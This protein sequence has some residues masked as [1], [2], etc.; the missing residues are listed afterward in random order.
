MIVYLS[1]PTYIVQF[2]KSDIPLVVYVHVHIS[3]HWC[4]SER[5][6]ASAHFRFLLRPRAARRL[7]STS[8]GLPLRFEFEQLTDS[9]SPRAARRFA[10]TSSGMPLRFDLERLAAWPRPRAACRFASTLSRLPLR[11]RLERHAASLPPRA[12]C[13]CA[14]ASCGLLSYHPAPPQ[15]SPCT[16]A[17]SSRVRPNRVKRF[18]VS[19]PA[20]PPRTLDRFAAVW[21]QAV[22]SHCGAVPN[23]LQSWR[24]RR[25]FPKSAR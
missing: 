1:S 11:S 4:D 3:A 6:I 19:E 7:A 5:L 9:L 13:R 8:S 10:C 18:E 25:C 14:S 2:A 21:G 15:P 24:C 23:P 22:R 12:A 16:P 17:R 20:E